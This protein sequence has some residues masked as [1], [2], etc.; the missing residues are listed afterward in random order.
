[1]VARSE[2]TPAVHRSGEPVET[3][4]RRIAEKARKEPG[5]QF[6]SLYH[7]MNEELLRGCFKRLRKDAAAGIDKMTK[8]MY[9]E[10]LEA[11]LSNL[12]DRLHRMA[13]IPQPVRRKYIPK[14]GSAKQRPLG[15]PCF[16]DKLVQAGLVRILESVYEQDFIEDSYGFRPGRSCHKALKALSEAVENKPV[17]HIV[18]ADIKGFFD[19]VNQEWLM[20][21]LAHRIEDKR[22]QRMVKRFLKAGV[23]EDG[24]VTVSD[25]GTPQGGVI[26]PLLANIYL[27]YA[28]DLWFE[29]VYRKN[30]PGFARLIRYAD[31]FVVCF[32]YKTGAERFR[33]ELSKR[34]GKFGLEVEPT[35]TKVME[36]GRFAVQNAKRRGERAET[37]DFLGFTHY[38][39]TK[40]D[41]KGFRMKR[42]TARKKFIA[43]LKIFKEWLK[44]ARI[45]KIK[46]LWGKAKAKLIGHYNYYGVTDNLRG[47]ARFGEEVKKLLFKWLNRRG[48]KNC[49]NW[50]KFNEMLKRFPLPKPR[51]KVSMFG[52]TVN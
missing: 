36:F 7:L 4:L 11:N 30:C 23:A 37:F 18:E 28:L 51:I 14:P 17:N 1:M 40:R 5:F 46:E 15:I 34:L 44:K 27:H 47:I 8:D 2:E 42:M 29:K 6:T 43:K 16:E 13:Y 50:E 39:G 3:K 26:S 25:E 20:K 12:V 10:N 21:F 41:G 38:C 45:L 32:Q 48:K 31:D 33:V 9:A 22:I 52:F 24:S 49:L 35:K 19:N